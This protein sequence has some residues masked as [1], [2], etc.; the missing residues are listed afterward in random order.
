M[1][2]TN[3]FS[4]NPKF[5]AIYNPFF[6]YGEDTT[7]ASPSAPGTAVGLIVGDSIFSVFDINFLF[8]RVI[9]RQRDRRAFANDRFDSF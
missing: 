2:H 5:L 4:P 9:E 1:N 7:T 6:A 8:V 3:Y